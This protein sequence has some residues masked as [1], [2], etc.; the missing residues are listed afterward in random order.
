MVSLYVDCGSRSLLFAVTQAVCSAVRHNS[1]A[2]R[3]FVDTGVA[4]YISA[5]IS[6][7]V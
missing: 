4:A 5:M 3:M 6:L 7:K 1:A 2:Q